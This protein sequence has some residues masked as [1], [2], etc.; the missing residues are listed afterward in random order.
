MHFAVR[1]WRILPCDLRRLLLYLLSAR[2]CFGT[3]TH[4]SSHTTPTLSMSTSHTTPNSHYKHKSPPYLS[5]VRCVDGCDDTA[6][7]AKSV[8]PRIGQYDSLIRQSLQSEWSAPSSFSSHA[9]AALGFDIT[10]LRVKRSG[11]WYILSPQRI[12]LSGS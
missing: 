10:A 5:R 7:L 2:L 12:T 11:C 8:V 4:K 3:F 9:H 6:A 1:G